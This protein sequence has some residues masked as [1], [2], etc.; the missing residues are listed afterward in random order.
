MSLQPLFGSITGIIIEGRAAPHLQ[1]WAA[2]LL[3]SALC[4]SRAAVGLEE[5]TSRQSH[6]APRTRDDELTLWR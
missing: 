3:Q 6:L 4:R 2:T 5:R 1:K